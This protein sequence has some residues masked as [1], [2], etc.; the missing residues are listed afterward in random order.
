MTS[1]EASAVYTNV[2]KAERSEGL[3]D[4]G[5]NSVTPK[6]SKNWLT[7]VSKMIHWM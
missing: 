1:R 6:I 3:A 5:V 7:R 4:V 2:G